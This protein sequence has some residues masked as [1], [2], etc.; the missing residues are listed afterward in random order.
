[1]TRLPLPTLALLLALTACHPAPA[2]ADVL[3]DPANLPLDPARPGWRPTIR[4]GYVVPGGDPRAA[5]GGIPDAAPGG[6]APSRFWGPFGIW[7]GTTAG[8]PSSPLEAQVVSCGP[9][10]APAAVPGPAG[11]LAVAGMFTTARTLRRRIS[12]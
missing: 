3:P 10:P 1:M 12:R 9:P 4:G 6:D 11:V 5:G 2:H 8:P 7:D